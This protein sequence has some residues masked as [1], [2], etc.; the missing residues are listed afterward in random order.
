MATVSISQA[1]SLR[2]PSCSGVQK[3]RSENKC[4][5]SS[6]TV[7]STATAITCACCRPAALCSRHLVAR[8]QGQRQQLKKRDLLFRTVESQRR[9]SR[10]ERSTSLRIFPRADVDAVVDFDRR[11]LKSL[12]EALEKI[13][14]DLVTE[15][16]LKE[17]GFRSTRRTKICCTIGPACCSF[18][19][20]EALAIGGMNIAR[21][22]M[23]HGTRQWHQNVIRSIRRLNAEKGYCVAI[24]VDTEGTEI[25]MGDL[26]GVSS[27]HAEDG[28]EWCFTVRQFDGPIPANTIQ[29][30]YEGF[31]E[32]VKAGDELVVDGGLVRFN[33]FEKIGPDVRCICTD[34]G[35]LLP[36]ASL[37]FWRENNLVRGRS[38][39]LPTLSSKDWLDIDFAIQERVDFIAVSYVRSPE[40]IK[41]L[42]SYVTSRLPEGGIGV[43]AKIEAIDSLS[44]LED[45]IR[46]SDGA[47][48][49]R[50]DLGAQIPL[51]QV[52]A[53]QKKVI[54]RC[55]DLNK[56]V[57]VASQLLE[58]MIEYPIPTRA[59]VA[60][61]AEA[62]RQRA[63]AL[64]LSGESAMGFFPDKCMDVLRSVSLRIEHNDRE[65]QPQ[66]YNPPPQL[67]VAL[68]DRVSEQICNSAAEM[69]NNLGV[70]A[71]FVYTRRGFMASLLS[72]NRP[73][74]PIFA[75]TE[76]KSVRQRLNMQW[77]L[78]P[79]RLDFSN[80]METD[81][82]R[83]F[84]LLKARGM[85]KTGDLVVAVSDIS[86]PSHEAD[87]LQSIQIRNI[88]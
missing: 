59:E 12:Q 3:Y 72:R 82:K 13:E 56:P 24:M 77:G 58:S 79:F 75:F 43:F 60:D 25:H 26:G 48:V 73:D 62:V 39:M 50:G 30:K 76:S 64:M 55:R 61:V 31:A 15:A 1:S 8:R 21:L 14:V 7:V 22:N 52:P 18:E 71:I 83:T 78:I 11:D 28:E 46:V 2:A 32:D 57:M 41:H 9:S 34:P 4:N 35:L 65:E 53:V 19:Q 49:A 40:V 37:T 67:S 54:D 70:D 51:E 27:V 47:M 38:A 86:P 6:Y 87:L 85:M 20:L 33:V 84:V 88:P 17:N 74:C 42:K 29:V 80:D 23:C 68:S 36:R 81:L 69:A 44:C 16:N 63:D 66:T 10:T 45:I 5:A